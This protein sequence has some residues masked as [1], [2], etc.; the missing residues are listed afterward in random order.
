[1]TDQ[2]LSGNGQHQR[3]VASGKQWVASEGSGWQQGGSRGAEGW[4]CWLTMGGVVWFS[5][6]G[7][8]HWQMAFVMMCWMW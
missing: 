8:S 2:M 5:C 3:W 1:M 7:I 6:W 4:R